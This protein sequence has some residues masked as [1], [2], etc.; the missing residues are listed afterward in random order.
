VFLSIID[1][2][3]GACR[4]AGFAQDITGRL[5]E[6]DPEEAKN[7]ADRLE[8]ARQLLGSTDALERFRAWRAPEEL[9]SGRH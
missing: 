1:E 8:R 5:S 3:A 7:L 4:I 2:W 6:L 9:L